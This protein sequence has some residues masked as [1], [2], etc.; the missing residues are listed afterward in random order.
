MYVI[1]RPIIKLDNDILNFLI[2][3]LSKEFDYANVTVSNTPKIDIE[4]L[5]IAEEIK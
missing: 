5:L 3:A 1:I 4:D 2:G